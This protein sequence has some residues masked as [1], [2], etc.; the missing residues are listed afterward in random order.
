MSAVMYPL[1]I[2]IFGAVTREEIE[3]ELRNPEA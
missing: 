1:N 3:H 2:Y